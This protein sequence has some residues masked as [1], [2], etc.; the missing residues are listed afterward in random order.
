MLQDG[1]AILKKRDETRRNADG[2]RLAG[3]S[4]FG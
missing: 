4:L 2:T 1:A 3:L